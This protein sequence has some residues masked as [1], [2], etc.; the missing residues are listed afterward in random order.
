MSRIIASAPIVY[1]P[2]NEK[3]GSVAKNWGSLGAAANGSYTGVD[4][5]NMSGPKGGVAPYFDGANDVVDIYSAA[6]AAAINGLEGS[7]LIWAKVENISVW[8]DGETRRLFYIGASSAAPYVCFNKDSSGSSGKIAHIYRPATY[9]A[10]LSS[11][12]TTRADWLFIAQ[13]WSNSA[14]QF[15]AYI[16]GA[17]SGSP[18]TGLDAWSGALGSDKCTIGS[19]A[20]SSPSQVYQGYLSHFAFWDRVLTPT[21]IAS[22]Y[23]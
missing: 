3:S 14:D 7:A 21:E 13:T 18:V 1:F 9:F 6:L 5:A 19:Y 4:L 16:D 2:L 15:I 17:Q 12:F 20:V 22:L 8:L 23:H 10:I 11:P